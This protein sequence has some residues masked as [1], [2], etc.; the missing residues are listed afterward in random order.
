[1]KKGRIYGGWKYGDR[2]DAQRGV[3]PAPAAPLSPAQLSAVQIQTV[4][5]LQQ[6]QELKDG[7]EKLDAEKLA[8]TPSDADLSAM[9]EEEGGAPAPVT[10]EPPVESVVP[11]EET[12]EPASTEEMSSESSPAPEEPA[13]PRV[14]LRRKD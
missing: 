9:L 5:T 7:L 12:A 4:L 11:A 1:M 10:V 13:T 8:A 2:R 14:T 3:K 6:Q